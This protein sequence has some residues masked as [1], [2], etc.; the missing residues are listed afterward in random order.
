[1]ALMANAEKTCQKTKW[2]CIPF[3]QEAALWIC[4]TQVFQS[5]LCYHE[6]LIKNQ[7][8]LKQTVWPCGI[9]NCLSIPIAEICIQFKVCASKCDFFQ[10]NGKHYR[11]KHLNKCLQDAREVEDNHCKK[12]ILA[13]I[14][15]EKD[16]S[17]WRRLNYIMGKPRGGSVCRVLV[18]DGRQEGMV[19]ENTTQETVQSAIFDDI[20]WKRFFL[21]EEAPICSGPLRGQFGYNAITKTAKAILSGQYTYPPNFD[22]ATREICEECARLCCMIPKDTISTHV[23]KEDYQRQWKGCQELT[24]LSISGKHFGHYI[25]GTQSDHISRFHALKATLIMKRGIVLDRWARSLSV[26]LEKC[27]AAH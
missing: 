19:I 16:R 8:N 23:S 21:A 2:G 22:Q 20:D 4:R 25:A 24:S 13:I 18:E 7:G 3:S 5:F 9:E 6:G 17:F 1:M 11:C 27:S 10:K 26:M 15:R 12:E 14:Q